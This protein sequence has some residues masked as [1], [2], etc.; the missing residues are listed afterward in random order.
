[1]TQITRIFDSSKSATEAANELKASNFSN[2][3]LATGQSADAKR[4][5]DAIG[6][7]ASAGFSG[8]EAE[9]YAALTKQG[10]AVL[11]F[12]V[13][14]GRGRLAEQILDRHGPSKPA[15]SKG[16]ATSRKGATRVTASGGE[17]ETQA[18]PLSSL[19]HLPVLTDPKP[20]TV[21]SLGDQRST[22]PTGLLRSDFYVSS[23]F[24]LPLLIKSKR[25]PR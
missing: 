17:T 15:R 13:P 1:M 9:T 18:A 10:G 19:F 24:G 12:E 20:T 14:F 23:L 21:D 22:L 25:D 6:S 5:G 11:S 3:R 2:V 8:P 7:F 4:G 16:R